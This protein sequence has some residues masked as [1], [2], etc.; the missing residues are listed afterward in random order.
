M[1]LLNPASLKKGGKFKPTT[2]I[3]IIIRKCFNDEDVIEK[4]KRSESQQRKQ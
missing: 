4:M 3:I 1:Y 2:A